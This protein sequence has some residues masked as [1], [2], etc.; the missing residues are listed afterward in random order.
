MG[1]AENA[2]DSPAFVA[3]RTKKGHRTWLETSGKK[4]QQDRDTPM[5]NFLDPEDEFLERWDLLGLG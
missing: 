3:D 2:C 5:R 1:G 4:G